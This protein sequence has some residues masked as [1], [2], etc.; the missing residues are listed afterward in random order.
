MQSRPTKKTAP[1]FVLV[2]IVLRRSTKID[3][4]RAKTHAQ[5]RARKIVYLLETAVRS[6][7]RYITLGEK[8]R[9]ISPSRVQERRRRKQRYGVCLRGAHAKEVSAVGLHG[10]V[11]DDAEADGAEQVV[12][13]RR[14]LQ[15][16]IRRSA[17]HSKVFGLSMRCVPTTMP[18]TPGVVSSYLRSGDASFCSPPTSCD[19]N[20]DTAP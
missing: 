13:N 6:H 1:P 19:V 18:Q 5:A 7:H 10:V 4:A 15:K 17:R 3:N 9:R 20:R 14:G 12:G 8:S 11:G 2:Q 16:K